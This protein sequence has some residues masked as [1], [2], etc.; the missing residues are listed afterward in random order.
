MIYTIS[1]QEGYGRDLHIGG[2][3]I[4]EAAL[5]EPNKYNSLRTLEREFGINFKR[6]PSVP[7]SQKGRTPLLD[8]SLYKPKDEG[9]LFQL[10]NI[11]KHVTGKVLR[12]LNNFVPVYN[13]TGCGKPAE[14][15]A[16]PTVV[17]NGGVKYLFDSI[18][19]EHYYCKGCSREQRTSPT[20]PGITGIHMADIKFDSAF[21]FPEGPPRKAAYAAIRKTTGFDPDNMGDTRIER[22]KYCQRLV[23][24]LHEWTGTDFL[25]NPVEL[26]PGEATATPFQF[27]PKRKRKPEIAQTRPEPAEQLGL[28]L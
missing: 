2:L 6:R 23:D 17:D 25:V 1:F 20:L 22:K 24:S 7:E 4:E 13:C 19:K 12:R 8:L 28:N 10:K 26:R 5:Y 16:V 27:K 15:I 21:A 3:S 18:D 14:R 11:V 9:Q